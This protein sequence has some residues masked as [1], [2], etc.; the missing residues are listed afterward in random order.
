VPYQPPRACRCGATVPHGQRC[1]NC[2]PPWS[3]QPE[4]W[5]SG[6][7]RRWRVLRAAKLAVNALCQQPGCWHLAEEVDHI[8]PLSRGGERWAWSNLQSLCAPHHRQK[9][10]REANTR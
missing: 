7:T 5:T 3:N 9:T 2:Y 6:S 8:V 1:V 4:S 10:Q